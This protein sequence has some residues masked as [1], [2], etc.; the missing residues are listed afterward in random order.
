VV[1]LVKSWTIKQIKVSKYDLCTLYQRQVT[2][3][4]SDI[5]YDSPS[6]RLHYA[7]LPVCL[8]VCPSR[9]RLELYNEKVRN[10]KIVLPI[11]LSSE[12]GTYTNAVFSKTT[13]FRAVVST[14]CSEKNTN[15]CFLA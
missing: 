13:Q 15:L 5:I 4:L 10:H 2:L 7:L 11:R 14:L 6:R 3:S 8:S 12:T 9:V 1:A